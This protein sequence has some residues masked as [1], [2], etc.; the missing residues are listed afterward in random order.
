MAITDD[1][2]PLSPARDLI[3][4]LDFFFFFYLTETAKNSFFNNPSRDI[5]ET[6][7]TQAFGH[8]TIMIIICRTRSTCY[9]T[10]I[11]KDSFK[12]YLRVVERCDD[13][14]NEK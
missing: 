8:K 9:V 7:D 10:P 2:F 3:L 1:G 12:R 4:Y 6:L 11:L 14:G 5:S 13:G